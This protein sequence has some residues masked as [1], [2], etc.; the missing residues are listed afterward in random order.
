MSTIDFYVL[1]YRLLTLWVVSAIMT[2][3]HV[4]ERERK[5]GRIKPYN[6]EI[7]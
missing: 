4:F 1:Y 6:E 3:E 5:R 7:V 2:I